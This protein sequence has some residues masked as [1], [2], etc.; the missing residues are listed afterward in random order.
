MTV[1]RAAYCCLFLIF[2]QALQAAP[3]FYRCVDAQGNIAFQQTSCLT[4]RQDLVEVRDNRVGWVP[5]KVV[6]KRAKVTKKGPSTSTAKQA[7]EKRQQDKSCWRAEQNLEQVESKLRRGYKAAAGDR[8]RAKRT[9]H[10][11]YLR[12]FC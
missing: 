12:E 9:R 6:K 5:P 11:S 3:Q 4:G 10:E 8:L 1:L 2:S 7:R